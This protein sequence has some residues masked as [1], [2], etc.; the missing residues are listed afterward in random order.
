FLMRPDP[1]VEEI[2]LYCLGEAA[3]R[4]A[5]TLHG[6][7]ALSN[8]EH[9]VIRDNR[10]N[11]PEFLA[12]LHKMLAKCLNTHWG[13]WENLFATEQANAVWLVEASDRFDKLLYLLLNPVEDLLVDRVG[14]WPGACCLQ[15]LL[16]GEP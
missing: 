14:D 1:R 12:H 16:T 3:E 11:F 9:L 5:V 2:F 6:W 7:M 4:Y 15:Q 13:R 8:H 10:G